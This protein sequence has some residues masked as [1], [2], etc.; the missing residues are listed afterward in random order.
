MDDD[1]SSLPTNHE[2]FSSQQN[3]SMEDDT[4][5][6]HGVDLDS[7]ANHVNDIKENDKKRKR[8]APSKPRKTF[9][10]CWKY[11]DPKFELD[12]NG[13]PAN[14]EGN[15]QKILAFKKKIGGDVE[16]G[17]TSGTLQTWKYDEKV[18]KKSLIELI[19]LAELPFRPIHS[20]RGIDIGRALLEYLNGWGIKNVM[21]MTVDNIASN[22]KDLEYLL[23]NLPTKY[24]D[25]HFHVIEQVAARSGMDSK[26]VELTMSSPNHFTSDIEDA[27]SS[28]N[29]LNYTSVSSDY[30]TAS[31]E[32]RSFTL[33]ENSTDNYNT[34]NK[35]YLKHHEKQVEDILNYLDE[36]Y[37]HHIEK[38]EE[39][40]I[41][42][43]LS[44]GRQH[45]KPQVI[46]LDAIGIE[47]I[48]ASPQLEKSQAA[49]MATSDI[50]LGT[51]TQR[52]F[53]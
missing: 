31:S 47:L 45:L 38:M 29:I 42:E 4:I 26:M 10:E 48:M 1:M 50:S 51:L 7:E 52:K 5:D 23:E 20:H 11:F 41:N 19:I 30:F 35:M 15:K 37:L 34:I 44:K 39:G 49:A 24:D 25:K 8:K 36:L 9:F 53:L 22:D 43:C 21:T 6:L 18:I 16:G 17:S 2:S 12:E 27:F 46:T 32:S 13:N 28:I 14:A 3:Y 33:Q 40:R